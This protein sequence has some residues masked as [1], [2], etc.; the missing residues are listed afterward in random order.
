MRRLMRYL[1]VLAAVAFLLSEADAQEN[2]T[3]ASPPAASRYAVQLVPFKSRPEADGWLKDMI[4]RGYHPYITEG[5]DAQG[6]AWYAVRIADYP[7]AEEARKALADF[8]RAESLAAFV[9]PQ[10][11]IFPAAAPVETAAAPPAP[12]PAA[13]APSQG[14]VDLTALQ[15]QIQALQQ[16]VTDLEKEAEARRML[17]MTED[18]EKQ[19]ESEI[20]TAAGREYT[21]LPRHNLNFEYDLK[22][23]YFSADILEDLRTEDSGTLNVERR[24]NHIVY[25]QLNL[26]YG[27]LNNLSMNFGLPFVYKYDKRSGSDS[28]EMTDLGDANLSL[29]YQPFKAGPTWPV[30]IVVVNGSFPTGRSP[31]KIN[32]DTELATG[33]GYY[34]AGGGLSFSK[35]LDPVVAYGSVTYT[36]PF[37]TTDMDQIQSDGSVLTEVAAGDTIGASLGLGFALSYRTSLNLSY[38]YAYHCE[39]K[40]F[41]TDGSSTGGS[42]WVTSSVSIGAGWRL[43]P[44]FSVYT[45]VDIGLTSDDPDFIFNLRIPVRFDLGG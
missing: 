35:T 30:L 4:R 26:E 3:A 16:K 44:R 31:Y 10:A 37:A 5:R 9:T 14:P 25:N 23:E 24:G 8:K 2:A 17:R 28:R 21:L 45:R 33:N 18:E 34:A 7:T 19:R 11:A 27:V 1:L 22:Y 32:S 42:S 15:H 12:A 43:S 40:Y 6:Q 36:H 38:Q 20:L 29:Q 39:S 41:F 13:P